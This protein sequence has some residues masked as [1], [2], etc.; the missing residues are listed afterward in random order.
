MGKPVTPYV[1]IRSQR[2]PATC[3]L[4]TGGHASGG[5]VLLR[6]RITTRPTTLALA[7]DTFLRALYNFEYHH[8]PMDNDAKR[9]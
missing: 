5:P 1:Q 3:E 7:I 4:A 8:V 2:R 9:T 6:A